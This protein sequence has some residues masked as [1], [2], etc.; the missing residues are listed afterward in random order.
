MQ[1]IMFWFS[2][3]VFIGQNEE[4][5]LLPL[6]AKSYIDLEILITVFS[7]YFQWLLALDTSVRMQESTLKDEQ[8]KD[9]VILLP[10]PPSKKWV[11]F[12]DLIDDALESGKLTNPNSDRESETWH[13]ES[14]IARPST[15]VRRSSTMLS[16]SESLFSSSLGSGGGKPIDFSQSFGS[17]NGDIDVYSSESEKT[18][19][20][21]SKAFAEVQGRSYTGGWSGKIVHGSQKL[22]WSDEVLEFNDSNRNRDDKSVNEEKRSR[23]SSVDVEIQPWYESMMK[24]GSGDKSPSTIFVKNFP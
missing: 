11:T 20:K 21:Y 9:E 6:L 15:S 23:P 12:D 8:N 19:D 13:E 2:L 5:L 7:L 17:D 16:S 3:G 4:L 1:G 10:R 22:G 14:E 24:K 18:D